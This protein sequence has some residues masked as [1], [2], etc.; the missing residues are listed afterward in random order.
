MKL[1]AEPARASHAIKAINATSK[2]VAR[3]QRAIARRITT[4][5]AGER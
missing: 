1:T 4:S 3:R 2:A 5:E